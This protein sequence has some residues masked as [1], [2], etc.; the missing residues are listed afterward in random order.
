MIRLIA[1]LA[2]IMTGALCSVRAQQTII[3]DQDTVE[4]SNHYRNKNKLMTFYR[5]QG[6]IQDAL[7]TGYI[8]GSTYDYFIGTRRILSG[9]DSIWS[10]TV[11]LTK[12]QQV[13]SYV[14]MNASY[15]DYHTISS[16]Q[17]YNNVALDGVNETIVIQ[18][19]FPACGYGWH[20]TVFFRCGHK[21]ISGITSTSAGE[22]N[23]E[24]EEASIIL[25]FVQNGLKNKILVK[26][27]YGYW[28]A[29]ENNERVYFFSYDQHYN[30]SQGTLLH[31]DTTPPTQKY[32]V[33]NESGA[34]LRY[35]PDNTCDIKLLQKGTVLEVVGE[36]SGYSIDKGEYIA[37]QTWLVVKE[38]FESGD[39]YFS[40][41]LKRDC[42]AL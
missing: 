2:F 16:I 7:I 29:E 31:D 8:D 1:I 12:D 19:G 23:T 9:T 10:M 42:K 21:L 28:M 18:H 37:D 22:P 30:W 24:T 33:N 14:D 11:F 40:Y 13:I 4:V 26:L 38:T 39:V 41:V 36:T 15:N 5:A 32:M 6:Q 17:V 20:E 25:P 27:Q 3:I 35:L 34:W